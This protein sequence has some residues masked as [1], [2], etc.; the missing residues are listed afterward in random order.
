MGRDTTQTNSKPTG[1]KHK[2]QNFCSETVQKRAK[3][4]PLLE[5]ETKK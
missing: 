1:N 5:E 4:K 3:S 2:M